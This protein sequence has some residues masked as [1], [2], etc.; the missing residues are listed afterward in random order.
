MTHAEQLVRAIR[1]R[2]MTPRINQKWAE[3]ELQMLSEQYPV[4]VT[5]ELAARMS[6]P[7]SAIQ[8]MAQ[9]CGFKKE[10]ATLSA[11]RSAAAVLNGGTYKMVHGRSSAATKC[12]TYSTWK[13][14]NQ[15][16]NYEGHKSFADYGG[17]GVRVCERWS[18]FEAFVADMG[19]RPEGKTLDRFPDKDGNYEPGNCRWATMAEQQR[20]RRSNRLVTAFGQTKTLIEWSEE[21]GIRGDTIAYRLRS[22]ADPEHALSLPVRGHRYLRDGEQI[23]RKPG[24]DGLLRIGIARNEPCYFFEAGERDRKAGNVR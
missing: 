16:C 8:K 3:A 9:I 24:K 22:G 1:R 10:P 17:R 7:A 5:R 23:V 18:D 11:I 6:R 12:P 20:N 14:M 15:R 13:S 21:T 2:A 4:S 19:E